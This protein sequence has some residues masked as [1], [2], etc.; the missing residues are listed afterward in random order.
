MKTKKS[1]KKINVVDYW[2]VVML[3]IAA[4]IIFYPF[5]NTVLVSLVSERTYIKT[6]L[7]LVPDKII[8]DS[9]NYILSY[10]PLLSGFKYQ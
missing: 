1:A 4:L 7:L 9:Y 2:L 8:F 10:K 3:S 5:Y 6:P